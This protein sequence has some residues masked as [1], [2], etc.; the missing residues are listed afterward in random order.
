MTLSTSMPEN[1]H[2]HSQKNSETT[3]EIYNEAAD[4]WVRTTPQ[5]LSDFTGRPPVFDLCGNVS[6]FTIVDLGCGEGYCA[7]VLADK[8][9]TQIDGIDISEEMVQRA[10]ES[11]QKAFGDGTHP[12]NPNL[13]FKVGDITTLEAADNT[14][15]LALGMFVYNYLTVEQMQSSF[16]EVYRTLKPGGSFVFSVPHPAF[17]FIHKNQNSP[18]HFDFSTIGGYFSA[19]NQ[20]AFGRI[21]RR[22][23]Q[24]LP[25]EM[26]HKLLNDYFDALSS[27]GFDTMPVVR[28][29]GVKPEHK[30][31]DERFFTSI[32]DIPLHMGIKVVKRG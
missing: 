10:I 22:D 30:D 31:L 2:T 14:Y 6:G 3:R 19:R 23:G 20:R 7:R 24:E 21:S 16:S 1:S 28:E 13:S 17:P 27:A 15:D 32:D 11:T 5:S 12:E 26:T 25:V 4:R 29:L 18:F 9:A 8:G